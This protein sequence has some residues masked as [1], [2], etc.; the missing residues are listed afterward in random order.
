MKTY[1]GIIGYGVVGKAYEK[2]FGKKCSLLINDPNTNFRTPYKD[3]VHDT[4]LTL[5][6]VPAPTHINGEIDDKILLNV[7]KQ[8]NS[9]AQ[10]IKKKKP[11]ICIKTTIL[12]HIINKIESEFTNLLICYTPEYIRNDFAMTD[13]FRFESLVIGGKKENCKSV[14]K[15][16]RKYGSHKFSFVSTYLDIMTAAFIKYME[17]NFLATKVTFMNEMYDI[18]NSLE[19]E[20]NWQDAM[21]AFHKDTR[22]GNSH[23]FV[24]GID[25]KRGWGGRCLPKDLNA[26]MSYYKRKNYQLELIQTVV[27][28]NSKIRE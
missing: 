2:Y 3:I 15:I 25:G 9:E 22:M 28:L 27:K 20:D 19:V 16:F 6:C 14:D 23:Y 4:I 7:L 5:I 13:V 26:F 8:L 10:Y 24:P 18:F 11:L 12:P 21:D 1:I 17:N